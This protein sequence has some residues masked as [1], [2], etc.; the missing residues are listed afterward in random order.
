MRYQPKASRKQS[1]IRHVSLPLL[2]LLMLAPVVSGCQ[3]LAT[4]TKTISKTTSSV[5]SS[6]QTTTTTGPLKSDKRDAPGIDIT[7]LSRY[8]GSIRQ[9][10]TIVAG[11]GGKQSGALIYQ[12]ADRVSE[13]LAFY[14][15]EADK[16][17]W[18]IDVVLDT[19]DGKIMQ[20]IKGNRK[21]ALN[22]ARREG[23]N[24]TDIVIQYREF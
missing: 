20:L 11:L 2:A 14:T 9:S 1:P 5:T 15:K 18:T 21:A 10:E 3:Q 12:T 7:D 17:D 8:P 19:K 23:I 24:F 22:I 16:Q 4:L 6:N 13:V